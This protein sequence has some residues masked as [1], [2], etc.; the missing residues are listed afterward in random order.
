[1]GNS[2]GNGNFVELDAI[3]DLQYAPGANLPFGEKQYFGL[4]ER[5]VYDRECQQ[6]YEAGAI[7]HQIFAN[8]QPEIGQVVLNVKQF[9]TVLDE[10]RGTE[11]YRMLSQE[12][13][14]VFSAFFIAGWVGL[15]LGVV[16]VEE[17]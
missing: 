5:V 2:K 8:E 6:G 1:M 11:Q 12:A 9:T 15:F 7:A 13:W 17:V 4:I 16:S 10:L 3:G 14:D